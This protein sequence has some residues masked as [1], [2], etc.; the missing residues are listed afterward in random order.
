[1]EELYDYEIIRKQDGTNLSLFGT[2]YTVPIAMIH[3]GGVDEHTVLYCATNES[4]STSYGEISK[5]EV[6]TQV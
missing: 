3:K 6:T 2:S 1:M 5:E 4:G